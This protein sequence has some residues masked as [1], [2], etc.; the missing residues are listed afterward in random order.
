M[1]CELAEQ[2]VAAINAKGIPT[3]SSA[4]E[5]VLEGEVRRLNK[6][7]WEDLEASFKDLA[8]QRFPMEEMAL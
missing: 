2:Y 6:R 8:N 5:R 3:I 7:V 4:W 1:L